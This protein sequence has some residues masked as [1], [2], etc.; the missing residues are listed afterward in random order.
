MGVFEEVFAKRGSTEAEDVQSVQGAFEEVFVRRGRWRKNRTDASEQLSASLDT[1]DVDVFQVNACIL[2]DAENSNSAALL[3]A[4]CADNKTS[5]GLEITDEFIV[6]NG[7]YSEALDYD[8][9]RDFLV[10]RKVQSCP[11]NVEVV[12]GPEVEMFNTASNY[13]DGDAPPVFSE[14]QA[15]NTGSNYEDTHALV[16]DKTSL[17]EAFKTGSN[18]GDIE[19]PLMVTVD[20]S[21]ALGMSGLINGN[22]FYGQDPVPDDMLTSLRTRGSAIH[23][24][25]LRMKVSESSK[26]VEMANDGSGAQQQW[27]LSMG[28]HNACTRRVSLDQ[29]LPAPWYE[30]CGE[31]LQD[32]FSIPPPPAEMAPM[33][34]PVIRLAEA[35][36]PPE[37]GTPAL[38]SIGSLLHHSRQ[39]KPC[40][41]FHTRGCENADNC[42]FCH[43]CG[44]GEKKKRLRAERSGKR[45]MTKA[46]V[47]NARVVLAAYSDVPLG[48]AAYEVASADA[49]AES[50]MIVE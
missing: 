31:N 9:L 15:F 21:V 38:P 11:V 19:P 24:T 5:S 10:E 34:A 41:F 47:E 45:E 32:N 6:K 2:E 43:L 48:G 7:F 16:L 20:D 23:R 44:P 37:L 25:I 13:G 29:M 46:A 18:Y 35:V 28:V 49:F 3:D 1:D 40:T 26:C 4:L 27:E 33:N 12:V 30:A 8:S 36:A 42:K 50:D 17:E 14:Q 22:T 39:C